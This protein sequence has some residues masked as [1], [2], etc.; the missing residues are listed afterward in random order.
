MAAIES[1]PRAAPPSAGGAPPAPETLHFPLAGADALV[2]ALAPWRRHGRRQAGVKVLL[3]L[4]DV[5]VFWGCF[6]VSRL[7]VWAIRDPGFPRG[8][9]QWWQTDGLL[10]TQT[11]AVVVAVAIVWMGSVH[12]HYTASR[13]RPW[14]DETR[15]LLTVIALAGMADAMLMYLGKWQFSRLATG[16]TWVLIA[17]TL[18]LARLAVQRWLVHAGWLAQPYVLVG[19]PG[20]AQEAAA[21]LASEPLMGY[22]PV[23]LV[24]PA[25]ALADPMPLAGQ[26]L[27]PMAYTATVRDFLAQPGPY[28]VVIALDQANDH[29]LRALAQDLMLTRDD[30]ALA[31]PL[32]GLPLLGMEISHFFSHEV[33]LMKARNNL[34]RRGPQ[35]LKRLFDIVVASLLLLLLS[36]LF[37]VL[38]WKITRDGGSAFFGHERI[39]KGGQAFK[40]YKFR[41]MF[42]NAKELLDQLLATNPAARAEWER[43]FKLKNDPRI[44][45]VGHFLRRTSLDELPQL[46]NVLK[47]DMSLVG[48]RPI[49]QQELER[50]G[51]DVSYYLMAQPG[52]TGLWQ[53]SGR[54]D[55]SYQRR[56]FFDAWYVRNWSLWYDIVILVRTV[57]VVLRQEGAV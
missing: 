57:R 5:A 34:R 40:C 13:R 44:S 4:L 25:P 27:R 15:Q 47:G 48:P 41:S 50:Y 46:W 45:K 23:A 9:L 26:H 6:A 12:G 38:A 18:P 36:P 30:V 37:A 35:L 42:T 39:G 19:A 1:A 31:P 14:W 32:N 16:T 21:A 54:S 11:F 28:Q 55:T 8:L 20:P 2:Q 22:H 52:M 56:V 24:C 3:L 43:D 10:R 49:V 29:W 51:K 53:I 17:I 33:L 7:T